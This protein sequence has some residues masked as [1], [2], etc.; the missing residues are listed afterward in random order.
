MSNN[1]PQSD[2][3]FVGREREVEEVGRL[4]GHDPAADAD[5]RRW[6]GQDASRLQVGAISWPT[7]WDGVWLVELAPLADPAAGAA[8]HRYLLDVRGDA[9]VSR[10]P[11][12]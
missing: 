12:P 11:R 2:S 9:G 5:G 10:S 4:S 6:G 8:G 3:S 1:L 7:E